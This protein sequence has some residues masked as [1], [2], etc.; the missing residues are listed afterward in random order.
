MQVC[1]AKFKP[2][3]PEEQVFLDEMIARCTELVAKHKLRVNHLR[4]GRQVKAY[5]AHPASY[6]T[7]TYSSD[8]NKVEFWINA[9]HASMDEAGVR[10]LEHALVSGNFRF[11]TVD[12]QRS[13]LDT[14]DAS[15]VAYNLKN[16]RQLK[17]D[18]N[19][20]NWFARRDYADAVLGFDYTNDGVERGDKINVNPI[21]KTL[22]IADDSAHNTNMQEH[23]VVAEAK[24][25]LKENVMFET[26]EVTQE[27]TQVEA[28]NTVKLYTMLD[29]GD[30]RSKKVKYG[31]SKEAK[32]WAHVLVNLPF[33]AQTRDAFEGLIQDS[34]EASETTR[35]DVATMKRNT[36]AKLVSDKLVTLDS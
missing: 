3:T 36:F 7:Y 26:Q 9:H 8:K 23:N 21:A 30:I 11:L 18:K 24:L 25:N 4:F 35:K 12:E 27:V 6:H 20:R 2:H 29:L 5:G 31:K 17:S 1:H 14:A 13:Y 10:D 33:V 16:G 32:L 28:P 22:D 15:I 34:I 19:N